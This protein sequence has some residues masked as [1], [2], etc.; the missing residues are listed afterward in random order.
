MACT[1]IS[2]FAFACRDSNGGIQEAKIKIFD[3]SL[4]G[5][6]E[7]SGIVTF[8]GSG[9]TGWYTYYCEKMTANGSDAGALSTQNGTNV[10]TQTATYI[11]NKLQASF[12]NE[13][14]SL[15]QARVHIALKDNNGT[16]WLFGYTRGM[17]LTTS[18][19][20]TGTNYEDRSGYT[21]TFVGSEPN[22][23][24]AISNYTGLIT[25]P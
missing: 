23:I 21:L 20:E 11:F 4:T 18:T 7:S 17:D 14:K 16:A 1:L 6:S 8:S 13:L 24:V 19:S 15:A 25:A 5:V 22:P 12:R 2:S 9:L 3:A 10:Y